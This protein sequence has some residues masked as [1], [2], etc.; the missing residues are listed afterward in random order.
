LEITSFVHPARVPQLADAAAMVR[1]APPLREGSYV[2]LVPNV[3]GYERAA[4]AGIKEVSFVLSVSESHNRLNVQCGVEESLAGLVAVAGRAAAGGIAVRA[5]LSCVFGCP[6]EGNIPDGRI[7]EIA[8]RVRAAGVREIVL[9]DTV[10]LGNPAQVFRIVSLV[11]ESLPDVSIAVHFHDTRGLGL[12]NV[13]AALQA[14]VTVIE[15]SVGGLGGCPFAPGAGGNIATEDLVYMLQ[16]MG[17]G[18]G[19]DLSALLA[20]VRLASELT[21]RP[22]AGHMSRAQG[23]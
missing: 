1:G 19:I 9:A 21:G 17:I 6:W 8:G 12:A 22:P 4:A 18:T 16:A 10:G 23:M 13:L 15:A 11:R 7:L 2:A 3:K 14:G 5:G 20:A